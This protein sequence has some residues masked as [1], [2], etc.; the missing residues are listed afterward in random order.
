MADADLGTFDGWTDGT[1]W[2]GWLNV[3]VDARTQRGSLNHGLDC[4][5]CV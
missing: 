4:P 2:N 1:F 3:E 5:A